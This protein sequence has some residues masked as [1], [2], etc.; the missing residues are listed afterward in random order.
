LRTTVVFA[1]GLERLFS[2]HSFPTVIVIDREGKTAFRSD[3]FSPDNFEQELT[4]AIR[5]EL[6]HAASPTAAANSKP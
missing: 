5:G 3:G 4:A 6:S 1:D 2:V